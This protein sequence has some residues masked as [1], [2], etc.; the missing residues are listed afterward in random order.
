M[1]LLEIELGSSGRAAGAPSHLL[2]PSTS[3]YYIILL[4]TCV[5][6]MGAERYSCHSAHAEV[7]GQLIKISSSFHHVGPGDQIQVNLAAGPFTH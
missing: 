2:S 7:K 1:W 4:L 5:H 3:S 6:M